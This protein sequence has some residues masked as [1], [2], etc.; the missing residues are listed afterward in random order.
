M[1]RGKIRGQIVFWVSFVIAVLLAV[2]FISWSMEPTYNNLAQFVS[3][4]NIDIRDVGL[5]IPSSLFPNLLYA[6]L[7]TI[8]SL[9]ILICFRAAVSA[10]IGMLI[11][12]AVVARVQ[13]RIEDAPASTLTTL[14]EATALGLLPETVS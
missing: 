7:V 1:A 12:V 11:E 2:E 4:F 6:L 3:H 5:S 10:L 14:T 13:Y 8:I 9:N